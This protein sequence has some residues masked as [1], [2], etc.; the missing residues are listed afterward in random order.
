MKNFLL[1]PASL[2]PHL[3]EWQIMLDELPPNNVLI[4]LPQV[5]SRQSKAA[6]RIA[7]GFRRNGRTVTTVS[8]TQVRHE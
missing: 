6:K 7:D 4:V 2:L 1:A 8:A 5:A 3:D